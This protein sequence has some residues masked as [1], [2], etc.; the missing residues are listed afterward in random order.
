[1]IELKL[2]TNS[3]VSLANSKFYEN[4]LFVIGI[5]DKLYLRQ[6]KFI[7]IRMVTGENFSVY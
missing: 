2:T 7:S 5:N 4:N 6:F 3:L 1:M